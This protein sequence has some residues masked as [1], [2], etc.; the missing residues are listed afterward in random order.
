MPFSLPVPPEPS[1]LRAARG[2]GWQAGSAEENATALTRLL[3]RSWK[4][5]LE[6]VGVNRRQFARTVMAYRFELW[7]WRVGERPWAHAVSGLI[8]RITRRLPPCLARHGSDS[9]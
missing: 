3:W 5:D 8:G 1:R 4:K 6:Q 7:L 9:S 2:A